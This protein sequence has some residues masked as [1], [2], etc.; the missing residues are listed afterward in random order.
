MP[1]VSGH[2][3]QARCSNS[4][5]LDE[6]LGETLRHGPTDERMLLQ[7]LS[8]WA[9]DRGQA[10]FDASASSQM[11][12]EVLRCRLGDRFTQLPV[13]MCHDIGLAL[14][15]DPASR[16]RMGRLWQHLLTTR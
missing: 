5:L 10:P 13:G 4:Q 3:Q 14:W 15:N 16:Q 7:Q 2:Q 8:Q 1:T 11:V 9:R 6:V 12:A